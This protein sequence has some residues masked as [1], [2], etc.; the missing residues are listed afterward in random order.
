MPLEQFFSEGNKIAVFGSFIYLPKSANDI[1]FTL[2]THGSII[3]F[4]CAPQYAKEVIDFIKSKYDKWNLE[5]DFSGR[6]DKA[7][8]MPWDLDDLP[9]D[10]IGLDGILLTA[11]FFPDND[12]LVNRYKMIYGDNYLKT[13]WYG[14]LHHVQQFPRIGVREDSFDKSLPLIFRATNR[15]IQNGHEEIM[16]IVERYE[17]AYIRL[18][19]TYKLNKITFFNYKGQSIQ[20]VSDFV[21]EVCG[22]KIDKAA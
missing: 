17:D 13:P 21:A 9:D 2:F 3:P 14:F 1:D 12:F 15:I 8:K 5:L 18:K 20:M 11:D 7:E 22:L 4:T 19:N 16:P 6:R 10:S